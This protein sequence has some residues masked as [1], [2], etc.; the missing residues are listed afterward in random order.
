VS[1]HLTKWYLDCV[2]DAGNAGIAYWAQLRWL[3]LSLTWSSSIVIAGGRMR[4]QSRV[5]RPSAPSLDGD[6]L[7][8]KTRDM[9]IAMT[10]RAPRFEAALLDDA[11]L[12]RCEMPLADV[13]AKFGDVTLN[14]YGYA[15]ILE[16]TILPW[17]LPIDELRWGRFTSAASSIV[18]I[19]W[20]GAKPLTLVLRD[21]RRAP[22][23]VVH[24]HSIT[25]DDDELRLNEARLMHD[26]PIAARL[27]QVPLLGKRLPRRITAAREQKWCSRGTLARGDATLARGWS[28]HELVSFA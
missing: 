6:G 11:L 18:W 28:I 15:E 20:R 4:T 16:M 17:T 9:D 1:F 25:L 8:W 7:R 10:R 5:G 14:G 21:G 27:A 12:W 24:D 2:D 3:E 23:A 13:R 19:D 26:A 22:D